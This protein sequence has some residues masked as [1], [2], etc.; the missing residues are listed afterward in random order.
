MSQ[1]PSISDAFKEVVAATE[2][3]IIA[4]PA[5]NWG[6]LPKKVYFQ[7]GTIKEVTDVLQSFTNA[8]VPKYPL[9]FL[10]RNINERVHNTKYG[11]APEFTCRVVICSLT[12]PFFRSDDRETKNF[13]PILLPIF[14]ELI[15]QISESNLFGMPA[16]EDMKIRKNDSYFYGE[17]EGKNKFNDYVDAI[18]VTNLS[19]K[20]N[21]FC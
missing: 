2:A 13:K 9:V 8:S 16:I 20:I 11:L 12:N 14:E 4:N 17:Y 21:N 3:A 6:T 19:L 1:L 5:L 7:H 10:V 15:R 18:D